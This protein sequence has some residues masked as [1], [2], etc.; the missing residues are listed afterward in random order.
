MPA[1]ADADGADRDDEHLA[2]TPAVSERLLALQAVDTEAD[3]LRLRRERLPERQAVAT[4]TELLKAWEGR[5]RLLRERLDELE[6]TIDSAEAETAALAADKERFDAQLKTIIAP[7]EAEALMHEIET[8]VARRDELDLGELAAL[9]EHGTVERELAAHLS[10]EESLRAAHQASEAALAGR[11]DDVDGELATIAARRDEVRAT[12]PPDVLA[13]YDEVRAQLGVA[14]SRL[15]GRRCGGC[16]L[17][18][19]AAE[20]DDARHDAAAT[21][22][23]ECPHCGRMLVA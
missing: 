19:S 13:R 4:Q 21:G 16:H 1:M 17:D 3:Q 20:A 6:R 22:I 7:R 12:L 18:L 2:A 11:V 14:V 15:D 23:T 5:R 8:V 9:E 10:E